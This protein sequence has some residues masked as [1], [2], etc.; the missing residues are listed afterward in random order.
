MVWFLLLLSKLTHYMKMLAM[1][2]VC[3]CFCIWI[4]CTVI[5]FFVKSSGYYVEFSLLCR[6]RPM[7]GCFMIFVGRRKQGFFSSFLIFYVMLPFVGWSVDGGFFRVLLF[8]LYLLLL[9]LLFLLLL[10]WL[11][12]SVALMLC[13]L[14]GWLCAINE[15]PKKHTNS[16]KFS[17]IVYGRWM[18]K[19]WNFTAFENSVLLLRFFSCFF[20]LH[21]NF[22]IYCIHRNG[23]RT[24]W[25]HY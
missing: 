9:L 22:N 18:R 13:L 15:E 23:R 5:F 17:L 25:A 12:V 6:L 20:F 19:T 2:H 11:S 8:L 10:W 4:C 14:A 24:D 7:D 16:R 21:L 3:C 1:I